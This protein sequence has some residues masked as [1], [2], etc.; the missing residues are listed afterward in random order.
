MEKI[1]FN[2]NGDSLWVNVVM[3]GIVVTVYTLKLKVSSSLHSDILFEFK[4]DNKTTDN[5]HVKLLN[6][7]FIN[8]N[9]NPA[10]EPLINYHNRVITV[11]GIVN[12]TQGYSQPYSIILQV[13][14]CKTANNMNNTTKI[15]S[16]TVSG[17]ISLPDGMMP[18]PSI[19]VK[20]IAN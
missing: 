8:P 20:L 19:F 17:N 9:G 2:P 6:K 11:G 10:I 3:G 18:V 7:S 16:V 12:A 1:K 14:Q 13:Y 5:D 15:G 4:G